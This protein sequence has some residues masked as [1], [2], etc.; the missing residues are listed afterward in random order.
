MPFLR[1]RAS[2]I[3]A[4][5]TGNGTP[6]ATVIA[7]V[8]P[9]NA[10]GISVDGIVPLA[11]KELIVP[12]GVAHSS[13]TGTSYGDLPGYTSRATNSAR[14][15]NGHRMMA[16]GAWAVRLAGNTGREPRLRSSSPPVISCPADPSRLPRPE[17]GQ[18]SEHHEESGRPRCRP[19]ES[20]L[21]AERG[22]FPLSADNPLSFS[23]LYTAVQPNGNSEH[24]VVGYP[25]QRNASTSGEVRLTGTSVRRLAS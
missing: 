5:Q 25:D 13:Q 24:L 3:T 16:D 14:P 4:A 9:Y 11:G 2:S 12:M 10:W 19:T 17:L 15:R 7:N 23:D 18:G 8:G 20:G 21:V 1:R 22:R 6:A